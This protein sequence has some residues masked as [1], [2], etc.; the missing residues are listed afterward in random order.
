MNPIHLLWKKTCQA[1]I[2]S[3]SSS[4][5]QQQKCDIA[6]TGR[7]SGSGFHDGLNQYHE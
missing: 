3:G 1:G 2:C 5:E 4:Q 6:A 7:N